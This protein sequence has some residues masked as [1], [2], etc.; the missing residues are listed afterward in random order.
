[1]VIDNNKS[2]KDEK[3]PIPIFDKN[4]NVHVN[5]PTGNDAKNQYRYTIRNVKS[6]N[7]KSF[8][9][10]KDYENNCAFDQI[11]LYLVS[12]L[13]YYQ[14]IAKVYET[15][16]YIASDELIFEKSYSS[17]TLSALIT[18]EEKELLLEAIDTI[19]GKLH[20]MGEHER[21]CYY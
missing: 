11:H 13:D 20:Q 9:N 21:N 2:S 3:E 1:M 17:R 8:G 5:V 19:K 14:S 6:I 7:P 12:L 18:D 15:M 4:K 10:V 16:K